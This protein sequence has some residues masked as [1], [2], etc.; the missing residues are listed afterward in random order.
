MG[1][2]KKTCFLFEYVIFCTSTFFD[3]IRDLLSSFQKVIYMGMGMW[4]GN[5]QKITPLK[6]HPAPIKIRSIFREKRLY[7]LFH[8]KHPPADFGSR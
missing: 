4:G 2:K 3:Q 1:N 8:A 7:R 5:E 6:E